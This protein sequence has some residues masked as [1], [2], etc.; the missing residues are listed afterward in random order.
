MLPSLTRFAA[1]ALLVCA[2]AFAEPQGGHHHSKHFFARLKVGEALP[3]FHLTR[4]DGTPIDNKALQGYTL[5]S[6]Y[7]A[8]CEPCVKEVPLLN[9]LAERRPDLHLLAF[10]FDSAK[11]TKEFVAKHGLAWPIVTDAGKLTENIGV[12]AYPTM[13]LFD[14]KGEL[15]EVMVNRA[16]LGNPGAFDA[17][18]YTVTFNHDRS[19]F[20]RRGL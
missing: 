13:A 14:R 7:F 9:A 10:T 15:V 18:L 8:E 6:F 4:L 1:V 17:W 12:K 3:E 11:E 16:Q 2:P 19:S 20:G 5:V